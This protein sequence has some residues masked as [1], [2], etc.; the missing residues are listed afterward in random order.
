MSVDSLNAFQS[1]ETASCGAFAL[2][3][4]G[5]GA[6]RTRAAEREAR[7]GA[8]RIRRGIRAVRDRHAVAGGRELVLHLVRIVE[9]LVEVDKKIVV[10]RINILHIG[11]HH[12]FE[13][14]VLV[15][16]KLSAVALSGERNNCSRD[17]KNG[18]E[19][20]GNNLFHCILI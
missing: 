15:E 16:L 1:L 3:L 7:R 8:G 10:E 11:K 13:F 17:K 9:R 20:C 2:R 12:D 6:L 4:A 19:N 5:G 14:A 18:R